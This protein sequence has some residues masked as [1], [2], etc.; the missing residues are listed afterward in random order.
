M[1]E[2]KKSQRDFGDVLVSVGRFLKAAAEEI[3]SGIINNRVPASASYLGLI[4]AVILYTRADTWAAS[5]FTTKYHLPEGLRVF[6]TYASIFSGW[7]L[8]GVRRAADRNRLLNKLKE[9]FQAASLKCNGRYPSLIEDLKIDNH[10]RRLRLHCHGVTKTDFENAVER[11]ESVL[12][13]TVIRLLQDEG[14][15]SKIEIIYT[16]KDMQK[17][18][19]LENPDAFADGQIPIGMTYEGP[20][21]VNMR[22]VGHILVAGQTGGGKSNFLKVVTTVLTRNN[23]EAKV[24]F[25]DFKGGMETA[26]IRNHAKN[27]GDNIECFDGTKKCIEELGRIGMALEERFKT[28]SAVGA[29]NFDD[30]LKKKIAKAGPRKITDRPEDERRTYII[31]DEIAQLYA[32]DPEV[33]K[34]RQDRAKAAVNRIA[35]QGRAAG[36]HLVVATQKPDAQSFDQTVKTNLPAVLCFPMPNQASSVSAIGTKR[37]FEINP[38]IQGRAVW[39]F[40]PK[41]EEVQTYLFA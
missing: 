30:Y 21:H 22:N 41:L 28:L 2:T 29:S 10:V 31:V 19:I 36:V 38:N 18:V 25:L 26:D 4:I 32:K 6:L 1:M 37:A 7:I 35:R 23:P 27:L 39:K 15:K 14:D 34:E 17:T 13:M 5:F 9:A 12:N 16:M 3:L 24:I 11:L 8:W 40:G 20:I 33:E